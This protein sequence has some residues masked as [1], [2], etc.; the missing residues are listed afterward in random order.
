MRRGKEAPR[1]VEEESCRGRASPHHGGERG[2]LVSED[3]L[4]RS[5]SLA[6]GCAE[7]VAFEFHEIGFIVNLCS[8]SWQNGPKIELAPLRPGGGTLETRGGDQG[9]PRDQKGGKMGHFGD[10]FGPLLASKMSPKL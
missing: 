7:H 1:R 6:R 4:R 5:L 8:K 2:C 9:G 10:P 3:A